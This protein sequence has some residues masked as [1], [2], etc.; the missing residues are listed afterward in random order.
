MERKY[1]AVIVGGGTSGCAFAWMAAKLGL[2]TLLVEKNSYLGGA[3]TAQLVI[4]A[5]KTNHKNLNTS[6]FE[7]LCQNAHTKN[8]QITYN[9]GNCGWF[10]PLKLPEILL[11]MLLDAGCD[12]KLNSLCT[13]VESKNI[14]TK[15]ND[16]NLQNKKE[17]LSI[18]IEPNYNDNIFNDDYID[19]KYND[20]VVSKNCD[21]IFSKY[22]IDA[23]GNANL[24]Q[25]A[26]AEFLPEEKSQAMSLRFIMSGVDKKAFADWL[27]ELDTD[28]NVTTAYEIDG[29]IHLSTACTWDLAPNWALKPLFDKAVDD[30]SLKDSD[31]A[32]FQVFSIAGERDKIAFNCPRIVSDKD[33]DPLDKNDAHI[34][35]QNGAEAIKRLAAFCV[36]CFPG[37][38]NA[39]VYKIADE[40]GVRATRRVKGRYVLTKEDIYT[41][42][43]F[44]NP[45]AYSNYPIDVH[46]IKKDDYTLDYVQKTYSIP[47]E[48]LIADGFTNLFVIG[49]CL[50][51]DFYAQAAVRI[52]PTC[53][54]MGEGLAKYLC[55][56]M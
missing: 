52:Q 44:D 19:E 12:V 35:Y 9:D 38:E 23:T 47:V 8:A 46:S 25:L 30:G 17:I 45:V 11:D 21:R 28:R 39:S 56:E 54:S 29:D 24:S 33:L 48:S 34:A 10:N 27:L 49:R 31:R 32:Y 5:M 41:A 6:F 7:A 14:D 22:F 36:K 1:D 20:N 2:K 16:N 40:L 3:I 51:A 18:C 53:F 15:H 26:G 4:P 42:K 55:N 13:L 37:F 43:E 50:S